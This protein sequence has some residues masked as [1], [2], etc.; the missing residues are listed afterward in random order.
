MLSLRETVETVTHFLLSLLHRAEA[1]VKESLT[2]LLRHCPGGQQPEHDR[3][4]SA[5]SDLSSSSTDPNSNLFSLHS[6]LLSCCFRFAAV[7]AA[8]GILRECGPRQKRIR[9][10]FEI[11]DA[12]SC[13]VLRQLT[14]LGIQLLAHLRS[15][16]VAVERTGRFLRLAMLSYPVKAQMA[17]T[18]IA[19]PRTK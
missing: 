3:L 4:V 12:L 11:S 6:M 13:S 14:F 10:L 15:R 19:T 9:K 7:T 8:T 1:G 2:R 5:A 17:L 16:L 18:N